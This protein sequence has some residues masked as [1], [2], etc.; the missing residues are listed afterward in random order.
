MRSGKFEEDGEVDLFCCRV[1]GGGVM[2]YKE[3][4]GK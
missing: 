2:W 1:Y 4:D 3:N